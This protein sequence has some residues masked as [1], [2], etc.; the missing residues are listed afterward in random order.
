MTREGHTLVECITVVLILSVLALIAV[1]RLNFGAVWGA[2]TDA[3]VRQ[4]ATDLR[5]TRMHAIAHAADNP[6]GYALVMIGPSP[7]RS[8]QII[9]LHDSAVVASEDMPANVWCT[10]GRSFE[11]G[12]LGNLTDG[13]DTQGRVH[14]ESRVYRLEIVPATGMVRIIDD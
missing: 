10:G 5:R 7:R 8:Y 9:D 12:P 11:F 13:S 2:Q 14:S 6:T 1:P 4:L 3:A